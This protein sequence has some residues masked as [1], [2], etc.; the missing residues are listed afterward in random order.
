MTDKTTVLR[1]YCVQNG[2]DLSVMTDGQ[3]KVIQRSVEETSIKMTLAV[4]LQSLEGLRC[5]TA[6]WLAGSSMY[7]TQDEAD[8]M[9]AWY[10]DTY[11]SLEQAWREWAEGQL[12]AIA[13]KYNH[14]NEVPT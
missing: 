12:A 1:E 14:A 2:I 6:Q 3:V 13:D 9:V 8:T 5:Q 10:D 7:K 11:T 4:S